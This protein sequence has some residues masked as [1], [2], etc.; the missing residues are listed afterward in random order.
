MLH[1]RDLRLITLGRLALVGAE[2]DADP[3][4]ASRRRKLAVLTVLA[5]SKRPI[6]RDRLAEMF[7]GNQPQERARHSLSST[8]SHLRKVLGRDAISARAAEVELTAGERLDVDAVHFALAIEQRKDAQALE[9]YAGPFLDGVYVDGSH[10]FD[11]WVAAER[12]R[13]EALFVGACQRRCTVLLRAQRWEECAELARRWL[14]AA[15][16]SADAALHRLEALRG[17]A[18]RDANQRALTE[19]ER[20]RERLRREFELRPDKSVAALAREI[21]A[22]VEALGSETAELPV[23]V[24]ASPA[25]IPPAIPAATPAAASIAR[26]ERSAS[27]A[28]RFPGKRS[29]VL[30][31]AAAVVVIALGTAFGLYRSR[32][33]DTLP[34]G[35]AVPVIAI[36]DVAYLG[37]DTSSAWIADGLPQMMATRLGRTR[38]VEVISTDHIRRIRARA[39][40]APRSVVTPDKARELARAVGAEWAIS[41]TVLDADTILQL[42]LVIRDVRTGESVRTSSL[43]A[44]NVLALGEAAAERVLIAAGA[45]R[46]GADFAEIETPNIEAYEH[47]VRF[48]ELR[49]S[50]ADAWR[51]LDAAIALDSGFIAALHTRMEYAESMGDEKTR[52][53]LE[54][55]F[56]RAAHRATD[57]DRLTMAATSAYRSGDWARAEATARAV[58]ERFPRD[59]RAYDALIR[60]YQVQGRWRDV[61]RVALTQLGIDSLGASVGRGP[62]APCLGYSALATFRMAGLGDY[63]GAEQALVRLTQLQ[64]D[65][66][67]AWHEL[68]KAQAAQGRFDEALA[69]LEHAIRTSDDPRYLRIRVAHILFMARRLDEADSVL[70]ALPPD[71][72]L[73]IRTRFAEALAMLEM[74][75][76]RMDAAYG[77]YA[78]LPRQSTGGRLAADALARRGD[79]AGARRAYLDVVRGDVAGILDAPHSQRRASRAST[80]TRYRASIAEALAPGGDI[81]FLTALA[82]SME[83]IGA[84]SFHGRDRILHHHARGFIAMHE[85]R[86]ADAERHFATVGR[87]SAWG[88]TSALLFE[89]TAQLEAGRPRDAIATLRRGYEV[90]PDHMSRYI[91]RAELDLMMAESFRRLGQAD[92]A[93]VYDAH[94]RRAWRNADGPD[95]RLTSAAVNTLRVSL[96]PR[97]TLNR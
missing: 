94:V 76:G 97:Y 44:R 42:D 55:A 84:F 67:H 20:L 24:V 93:A 72:S 4:L 28:R 66:S 53:E 95:D 22:Q 25:A 91:P 34:A 96:E 39:E 88:W 83:R 3:S 82:D 8:L 68:S 61:E 57:W 15:P 77:A 59:P 27:P 16:L 52:A 5:L 1:R 29:T 62:C 74:E 18:T 54:A 11:E 7:W 92:S 65:L 85:R 48:L 49:V 81:V 64:P 33:R 60:I 17:P 78:G 21:V 43:Q 80:F 56:Q 73:T 37:Q 71:T 51:E 2:G 26:E 23:V 79:Y 87:W 86:W 69:S 50:H 70:R 32:T 38:E 63:R 19:F 46:N 10:S 45:R 9:L 75:R 31:A 90:P 12:T 35:D 40:I 13:L 89:A 6:S 30:A 41:G 58:A 36:V 14:A 47:Y